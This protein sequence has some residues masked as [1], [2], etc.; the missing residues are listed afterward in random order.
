MFIDFNQIARI[1]KFLALLAFFLPWVTVSCSNT[2]I[3]HATG[4]QLMTGD[5]QPAGPLEHSQD[6]L[7]DIKPSIAVIAAFGLILIGLGASLLNRAQS[8]AIAMLVSA[9]LAIGVTY[10]GMAQLQTELRNQI[11]GAQAHRQVDENAFISPETQREL[12]RSVADN[13]SVRKEDGYWLTL[14]ALALAALFSLLT[15]MRRP[16]VQPES[17]PQTS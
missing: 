10:F 9:V 6:Q 11:S 13:I 15:L 1:A 3:L 14:G 8:A 5:P 17:P 12:S 4:W 2:E 7:K 16:E